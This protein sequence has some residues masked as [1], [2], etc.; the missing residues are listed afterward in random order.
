MK[1]L[2][3]FFI[4][5]CGLLNSQTATRIEDSLISNQSV[6]NNLSVASTC[7]SPN[8]AMNSI[9]APP[10]SY[11]WL[12][13]NGYCNPGSYGK[14]GTVC[15]TF[16]PIQSIITINSGYSSS[17]CGSLTFGPFNLFT[18]SPACVLQGAGLNFTLTPGQCYTW[19]MTYS[20]SGGFCAFNDFCPY[21]Q[22]TTILPIEIS[23]FGGFTDG[24]INILKWKT[25]SETNNDFFEIQYST[26]ATNWTILS[27]IKGSGNSYNSINYS[28]SHNSFNYG[29][30]YYRLKQV[31]F[32]GKSTSTAIVSIMNNE[33]EKINVI[34]RM[35]VLGTEVTDNYEGIYIEIYDD[36]S[37]LK[38]FK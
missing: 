38:K 34:K 15:W 36:G 8:G 28:Y 21:F 33:K 4:F 9:S 29:I 31:D 27:K 20:G 7:A 17:G 24:N 30:N 16:T 10:I 25:M 35:T 32:D 6:K 12:Q 37:I 23:F 14:N 18:C 13:T 19:C 26:D 1:N 2:L 11:V 22:E 5:L 3:I